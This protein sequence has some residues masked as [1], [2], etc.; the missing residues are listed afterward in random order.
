MRAL[1]LLASALSVV[2]LAAAGQGCIISD[3]DNGRDNCIELQT[4]TK[5]TLDPETK[6]AAWT[7]GKGVRV[8]SDNGQVKVIQGG[9]SEVEATFE[10]FTLNEEG[11]EDAARKEMTSNLKV[12][13]VEEG[14]VIVVRA[15]TSSDASGGTGADVTVRLPSAFDSS[16]DVAQDNGS[17]EVDLGGSTPTA[18]RVHTENGT[19][20]ITGAQGSLDIFSGNGSI[21]LDVAAWAT[22]DGSVLTENG[23][24]NISVPSEA[25]GTISFTADGEVTESGVPS[26][27]VATDDGYTMNA[28]TGGTVDVT[29]E[30]GDIALSVE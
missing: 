26:A 30:F 4:P 12:E 18:T 16:F 25:D 28:G 1:G 22:A 6:S 10:A 17:V 29:T 13:V 9:G 20:T 3:C 2:A 5:Y 23:D 21:D 8:E 14:G 7:T 15:V 24:I 11:K 19:L 27:W